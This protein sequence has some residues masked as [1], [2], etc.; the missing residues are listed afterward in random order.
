MDNNLDEVVQKAMEL[1]NETA[2][3]KAVE[4]LHPSDKVHADRLTILQSEEVAG[5]STMEWTS[6]LF[7][8]G[9]KGFI[10]DGFSEKLKALKV[11]KGGQGR[12][13]ISTIF[14]PEIIGNMVQSGMIPMGGGTPI[15]PQKRGLGRTMF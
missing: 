3:K 11:S 15:P 12:M 9:Q 1:S 4:T 10:M 2:T 13:E 7:N 5:H 8:G 6:L 14:K